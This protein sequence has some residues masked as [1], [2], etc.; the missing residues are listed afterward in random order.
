MTAYPLSQTSREILE[1]TIAALEAQRVTLGDVVV[2]TALRPLREQLAALESASTLGATPRRERKAITVLLA[3]VKGSTDLAE[4]LP[5]EEWVEVMN[6]LFHLLEN[7]IYRLGG[8]VNQFRGDGLLAFFGATVAHE[9]DPERAVLAALAMQQA[10][11]RYAAE[12]LER[13]GITLQLRVGIHTGEVIVMQV[14][15]ARQ[16]SED[17]AMGRTVALAARM[18]SACEP[19]T[20][21]VTASTYHLVA[22]RFEWLSLGELT[23]KG[24]SQPVDAYRPLARL[25][26][27]GSTRG[28]PGLYSPLVGRDAERW[29]LHSAVARVQAGLGGIVTL[30]GEAGLGKSRLVTETFGQLT[31]GELA[32]IEGRCLSYGAADA[33]HL[34]RDI[35]RG[36][37]ALPPGVPCAMAREALRVGV[38]ELCLEGAEEVYTCLAGLLIM[39]SESD[40]EGEGM[41]EFS[42]QRIFAVIETVLRAASQRRPLVIV[43]EDLHWADAASLALLEHVLQLCERYPVLF[44]CVMRP[45]V[46]QPGWRLR[47]LIAEHH[48]ARHTGLWLKPL[49]PLESEA[50]VGN[51]LRVAML[52]AELRSHILER[53]EGNPF[54]VEEIIRSLMDTGA[55]RYDPVLGFWQLTQ[56]LA[57]ITIP[58]TLQG[59]LL[60]RMD[61]LPAEARRVLQVASVIGRL[62]P[63]SVLAAILP[64]DLNLDRQLAVLEETGMVRGRAQEPEH[65]LIFKHQL[66]QEAAYSSLLSAERRALHHEVAQAIKALFPDRLWA[67]AGLLAYHWQAAGEPNR[68]IPHLVRAGGGAVARSAH[69]EAEAYLR[70]ALVLAQDAGLM[71]AEAEV[72][73]R[74]ALVNRMQGNY[75]EAARHLERALEIYHRFSNRR[76]EATLWAHL[77]QLNQRRGDFE[78]AQKQLL[79]TLESTRL[80]HDRHGEP[81]A[82][83]DLGGVILDQGDLAAAVACF[84]EALALEQQLQDLSGVSLSLAC[85]SN[86][87]RRLGDFTAARQSALE[88]VHLSAAIPQP[89]VSAWG[90]LVSAWLLEEMGDYCEAHRHARL[91]LQIAQQRGDRAVEGDARV[92]LAAALSGLGSFSEARVSFEAAKEIRTTLGEAHLLAEPCAG[93]LQLALRRGDTAEIA[94]Q[95]ATLREHLACFPMQQGTVRPLAPYAT[96]ISN[97]PLDD[98]DRESVLRTARELLS[99]AA[100][101]INSDTLRQAYLTHVPAHRIIQ[102]EI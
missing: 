6:R 31:A 69:A 90:A 30:V 44:L 75:P 63:Y 45:D 76:R 19:G 60:A 27:S 40:L 101:R 39:P 18:E 48:A 80:V 46:G 34:W 9:D 21:L 77:G 13:R 52:P 4:Q 10:A 7:E 67:Q 88:A 14:G 89:E 28:I 15:D 55:I 72:L 5:V 100:A 26:W 51:L 49:N 56:E 97:L 35:L 87:W 33:F 82:L 41:V 95:K 99:A 85:L 47:E 43:C 12:L 36:L 29:A 86:A 79:R 81:A 93:L 68:A 58:D 2:E 66:T 92:A 74:L 53:A 32:W 20:V 23:V 62:F 57:A 11:V 3:D 42:R 83:R 38:A 1:Q 65:E 16:H 96:L 8:E 59:V 84:Q 91:A 102:Q 17:T 24:F 94:I 54:Y 50:L 64:T 25:P 98:P 78:S 37:F 22:P 73:S 71:L 61:R 70:Q